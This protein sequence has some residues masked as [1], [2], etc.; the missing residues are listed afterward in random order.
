MVKIMLDGGHDINTPGK[1]ALDGSMRE[2]EFN[3]AVTEKVYWELETYEGVEPYLSHDLHDGIDQTLQQRTDLAN[4]LN[5]DCFVSIHANAGAITARG[6]ETFIYPKADVKTRQLANAIHS[7]LIDSTKMI[8][9]GVKTADFHVLRETK[10]A[11]V[12]AECGFMTNNEDLAFLKSDNYRT[13]CAEGIVSG[14][15]QYYGLKK[16]ASAQPAP[17][18]IVQQ[19]GSSVNGLNI[20]YRVHVQDI[21]WTEWKQNGETAG[22]TGQS[23]RIEAIEIKLG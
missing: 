3:R 23:K 17:A 9:R 1:R 11:A 10:M 13:K 15:V 16:K 4:K 14:L 2:F 12:L 8:N 5:V 21:G 22:T 18:P 19:A 20:I 6:I 7:G